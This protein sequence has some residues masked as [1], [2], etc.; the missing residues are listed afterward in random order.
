MEG[1][2]NPVTIGLHTLNALILLVAVYFLLYKPVR[3]FM[4][5]REDKINA[6]LD[7]AQQ[8][9]DQAQADLSQVEERLSGAG[10]E[11]ANKIADGQKRAQ[12]MQNQML[13]DARKAGDQIIEKAQQE[14]EAI[15]KRTHE[16]MQQQAAELAIEI[17]SKVLEREVK[18]SD[19][20]QLVADFLKKVG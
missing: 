11:V 17:A 9:R 2:F 7:E 3:K 20:E 6:Q 8:A 12:E 15:L 1:L 16:S 4:Q 10:R 5:A 14:A 13:A 18:M 19:H